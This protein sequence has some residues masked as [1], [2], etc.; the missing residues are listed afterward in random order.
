MDEI[1]NEVIVFGII[2][3][4]GNIKDDDKYVKFS[5]I[6]KKYTTSLNNNVYVSLNIS[7]KLYYKYLD[8]FYK[9]SKVFIKGYLNSYK[10]DNKIQNFI[11]VI[12][13]SNKL[14]DITKGRKYPHIRYDSDGVTVWNGKRCESKIPTEKDHLK[15]K[16]LLEEFK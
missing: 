7:R 11:T 12:D 3:V 5:I 9:D 14:E 13:I 8:F 15:M 10:T 16:K 1:L 4:I 6:S 2:N